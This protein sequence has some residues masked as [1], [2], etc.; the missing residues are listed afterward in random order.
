MRIAHILQRAD[1]SLFSVPVA[2]VEGR[3][4]SSGVCLPA[5]PR[6]NERIC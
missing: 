5:N 1:V 3:L 2:G 4:A 6:V